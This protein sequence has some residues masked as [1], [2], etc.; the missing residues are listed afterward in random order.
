M[1]KK[2]TP[3]FIGF[4]QATG[5]VIYVICIATFINLVGP[6]FNNNV[7]P[8]YAPII[9][10]ILFVV[11][12]VISALL[13]LGRVGMLFLEKKYKESFTLLGCTVASILFYFIFFVLIFLLPKIE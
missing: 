13:V 1:F 11:S 12:A 3:L 6:H 7:A 8:F 2:P 4:L 9:M 10:L 5:F